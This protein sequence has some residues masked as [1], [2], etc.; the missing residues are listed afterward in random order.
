MDNEF[1]LYVIE[2]LVQVISGGPGV[3]NPEPPI[4]IYRA[5]SDIDGFLMSCRIDPSH[6]TGSR[7]PKLREC[8]KWAARQPNGYDLLK[9]AIENVSDPRSFSGNQEKADAVLAYL[10]QHLNPEGLQ[11]SISNGK[12]VLHRQGNAS[13]AVNAVAEKSELL[14]FDTVSKSLDRALANAQHDPEDAVTAACAMVESVCRSI[15]VELGVP[16]PAKKDI[17][18]LVRAVQEPLNLSPGRSDLPEEIADDVRQVLSGLT[19]TARG[20][21]ALR[22]H[23]GDA[24]GYERGRRSIDPRIARLAIHAASTVALF[25]IETWERK[26]KRA[27]PNR[28]AQA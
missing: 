15:L 24:H 4:G 25:F 22:T 16:L 8:L 18:V 10:N 2:A 3:N 28:E 11:V 1:S 21:G 5:A 27:L 14:D 7:L 26:Q 12:A 23:G 13:A 9:H 17:S 6:G 20:I 19:T